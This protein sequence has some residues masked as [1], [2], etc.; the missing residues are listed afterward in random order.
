MAQL[1]RNYSFVI[2]FFFL[3]T[4][5]GLFFI[6]NL[7]DEETSPDGIAGSKQQTVIEQNIYSKTVTGNQQLE[8]MPE[9]E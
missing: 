1:L 6:S 5:L 7:A 4:A 8:A 2:I 3:S 9:A